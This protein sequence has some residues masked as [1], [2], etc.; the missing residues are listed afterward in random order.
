MNRLF[1][2]LMLAGCGDEEKA[3]SPSDGGDTGHGGS[4]TTDDTGEVLMPKSKDGVAPEEED[5]LASMYQTV[6][7]GNGF[8]S[9]PKAPEW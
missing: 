5:H 4:V 9:T 2:A 6:K 3:G 7:A 8:F 1:L